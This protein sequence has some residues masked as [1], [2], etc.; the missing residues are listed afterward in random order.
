M[1]DLHVGDMVIYKGDVFTVT[2]KRMGL[3]FYEIA[4]IHRSNGEQFLTCVR[5][6]LYASDLKL[7][8]DEMV[9]EEKLA[10]QIEMANDIKNEQ[11][12]TRGE[13]N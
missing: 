6:G 4:K 1:K 10:K 9:R 8:V 2:G 11:A 13:E 5:D 12:A 7:V 3:D